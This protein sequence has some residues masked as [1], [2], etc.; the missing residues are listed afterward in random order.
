MNL[1]QLEYII[2][3]DRFRSFTK[4]SDHCN[5]TQ[6][7]LSAMVKK[8]EEELGVVIFDRRAAPVRTTHIGLEVIEEAKISIAHINHIKEMAEGRVKKIE[9]RFR[10]GMIP[11]IANSLLPRIIKPIVETYPR[12]HIEVAEIITANI[13]EQLKD[14]DIDVGIIGTP[15]EDEDI[16]QDVLYRESLLVYGEVNKRTKY[17]IPEDVRKNKVWLLEE[18]HCL[19]EQMINLCS[20]RK[21]DIDSSNL[22]FE[23]NSFD[24]LLNMVDAFGGLTVIPELY[25][26]Q[27]PAEKKKRV[28]VFRDPVPYREVSMVY[29]RPY[30]RPRIIKALG[31]LIVKS[32]DIGQ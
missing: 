19:R 28:H 12:L 7:T 29:Y 15:N 3:V 18:G 24:T 27:L 5:V 1:Q 14:G 13:Y 25:Y 9:G 30:A 22:V 8:L 20:L 23:A 31:E 32:L 10:I 26:Q 16:S 4:A 21:K 17:V 2:A 6:A 11:T